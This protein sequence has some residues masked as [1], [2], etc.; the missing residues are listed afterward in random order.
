MPLATRRRGRWIKVREFDWEG[1]QKGFTWAP[2]SPRATRARRSLWMSSRAW[3]WLDGWLRSMWVNRRKSKTMKR[4][5]TCFNSGDTLLLRTLPHSGAGT[6]GWGWCDQ[7][8]LNHPWCWSSTSIIL[9]TTITIATKQWI[10]ENIATKTT[11]NWQR[12]CVGEILQYFSSPGLK[13]GLFIQFNWF[14]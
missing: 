3:G 12:V 11:L 9:T 6:P 1:D 8:D 14:H 5:S 10:Q 13:K 7:I 2:S 4:L